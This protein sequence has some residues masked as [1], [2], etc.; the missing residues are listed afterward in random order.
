MKR[1]VNCLLIVVFLLI[2]GINRVNASVYNG[3]LYEVWD[4]ESGVNVYGEESNGYMDY[5]SWMIKST[6]DNKIYYCIDPATPLEGSSVGSH[7]VYSSDSDIISH[8]ALSASKLKKVRLL[9]YYGYGY[10]DD[11]YDHTS[12]KWYGI[13]QVMIWR[14]MRPDLTW[15]F[16]KTR[17]GTASNSNFASEVADMNKLVDSYDT[18]P[19]FHLKK[20][21]LLSGSTIE[22]EDTNKVLYQYKQDGSN[23]KVRITQEANKLLVHS[24][25]EPGTHNIGFKFKPYTNDYFGA[26]VS[27]E[28]QDIIKVG[29]P[30]EKWAQLNIEVYGGKI[31]LQKIDATT[32]KAKAQGE[33]TFK[34][35]VYEVFDSEK[36]EIGKITTD[37][38]GKGSIS[39]DYGTYTLKEKVAPKGYSLSDKEYTVT[40]TKDNYNVNILVS[41][42]V[43]T[44]KVKITK[45]KGG[46]G[47][48]FSTE[49]GAIFDV[50]D[51]DGNVVDKLKTNEKGMSIVILPY[52][53]YILHQTSGAEGYIFTDD[54]LMELY[55]DKIYE[56]NIQNLRPSK[57]EFTKL[58]Y[59][60]D[61]PVP[62]TLIEIYKD[63]NTLF[64]KGK[65]D[66]NGKIILPNLD[67][68]KYYIIEKDAPKY[69]RLNNEKMYF[70]V[71][72]NGKVIKSTMKNERK[73]GSLKIIKK[74][75]ENGK[76]L[77]GAEFDIYFEDGKKVMFKGV[78]NSKGEINIPTLLAGKYCVI[79]TKAPD[80]YELSDEKRCFEINNDG[81]TI[82][83]VIK[84]NKR[85]VNVP[86]TSSL[87][88]IS[89]IASIL[90]MSGSGYFIY[91]KR[92]YK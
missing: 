87:S 68:G 42:K 4:T 36:N 48:E 76:P 60:T 31:N 3:K 63:D 12:K 53:K 52:G 5:N 56:F 61:E 21:K 65:T 71:K 8:T 17:N 58:D 49:K 80:G 30:P 34:G 38:K 59:S 24:D 37:D 23:S 14:V 13:T 16:K 40:L 47:E 15:T 74:D 7:T 72:E 22:I 28:Y 26:F 35:A 88:I 45:T 91:E 44:G 78:T 79:E 83:L 39:L 6:A 29:Q 73:E 2:I 69:Y 33:A 18:N 77:K 46:S 1:I 81:Q 32:E 27:S 67:I 51:K 25:A 66:K 57:L 54:I 43:I 9:A 92:H 86:N 11:Y 62:N 19:S 41:D 85:I 70:E 90:I 50:I 55:E 82:E 20:Y 10:K 64:Y 89:I 75:A 84:N